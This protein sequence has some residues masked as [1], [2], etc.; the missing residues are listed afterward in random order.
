MG[1][2][3][4]GSFF[5]FVVL[6]GKKKN[7]SLDQRREK[8]FVRLILFKFFSFFLLHSSFF[9]SSWA[10]FMGRV[11]GESDIFLGSGFWDAVL[12]HAFKFEEQI[13]LFDIS[14]CDR[15]PVI[16]GHILSSKIGLSF[17]PSS[18]PFLPLSFT[19]TFLRPSF[20]SSS[21]SESNWRFQIIPSGIA[22]KIPGEMSLQLTWKGHGKK[23][24]EQKE[25]EK[26]FLSRRKKEEGKLKV[27][28]RR[29]A[30]LCVFSISTIKNGL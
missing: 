8:V 20:P 27:K 29:G 13:L 26:T 11:P 2:G 18:S 4:F 23:G 1:Q 17:P 19:K 15:N 22:S 28:T 21:S 6:V 3:Q 9:P 12:N 14:V 30:C 24:K 16:S 10:A 25:K 7:W 5:L